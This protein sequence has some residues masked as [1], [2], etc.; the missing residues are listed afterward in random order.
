MLIAHF[1]SKMFLGR[2]YFAS[3]GKAVLGLCYFTFIET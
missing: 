3:W 2:V 1:S